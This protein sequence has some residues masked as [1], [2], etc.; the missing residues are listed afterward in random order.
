MQICCASPL[1]RVANTDRIMA[2]V[3]NPVALLSWDQVNIQ[4]RMGKAFRCHH[5]TSGNRC[6][7]AWYQTDVLE[8]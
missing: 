5:Q 8:K 4:Q 2:D 6:A 7:V 3:V 1:Y